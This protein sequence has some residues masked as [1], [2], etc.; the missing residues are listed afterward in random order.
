MTIACPVCD[1]PTREIRNVFSETHAALIHPGAELHQYLCDACGHGVLR[2]DI[3]LE[4]LYSS[5]VA[6]PTDHA[7][8]DLRLDFIRRHLDLETVDGVIADIGGGPGELAEQA[9][10]VTGRD[11]A[12][13]IDFVDRVDFEQVEFVPLDLNLE[14]ARLPDLLAPH[15]KARNLFML[16]H[17]VE[18]L[19]DPYDLLGRLTAFENSLVYIEV[20]NFG[21]HHGTATLKFSLNNLDHCHYFTD[22][23]LI[24]LVHGAGF[25]VLAFETQ[26]PPRMPAI[27]VLCAPRR[28]TNALLDYNDHFTFVA[29]RLRERILA[30]KP[31]REIWIW[32]FSAFAAKALADLGDERRRVR[33]IMDTRFGE[34]FYQG[35]PV[36][37]EPAEATAESLARPPLILCGSTYSTVQKVIRAKAGRLFPGAEFFTVEIEDRPR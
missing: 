19:A 36:I 5:A 14:T 22:R 20:P 33:G 6:L 13:V 24:A 12:Y 23:S 29:D 21:V 26:D 7:A 3:P 4:K 10:A 30:E 27:R 32:G 25:Q 34:P 11:R 15:L 37:A 8:G 18:H 1:A 9:R 17:V 31:D 2:H 35:V 16:S 28:M